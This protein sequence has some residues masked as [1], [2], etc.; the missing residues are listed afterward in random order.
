[1]ALR[2]VQTAMRGRS[3]V[4][5][6]LAAKQL[7]PI[8]QRAGFK[9]LIRRLTL[10]HHAMAAMDPQDLLK[11]LRAQL[12]K[13]GLRFPDALSEPTRRLI[14]RYSDSDAFDNAEAMRRIAESL[15]EATPVT[16]GREVKLEEL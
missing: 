4:L 6:P 9:E 1:H 3:A 5:T 15:L 12:E 2:Q 16:D 11:V 10:R 7:E 14:K 8:N 13:H